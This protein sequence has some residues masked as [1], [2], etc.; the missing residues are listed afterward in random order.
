MRSEFND[1]SK[2]FLGK[3]ES[4]LFTNIPFDKLG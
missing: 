3:N 4:I 1:I 2:K